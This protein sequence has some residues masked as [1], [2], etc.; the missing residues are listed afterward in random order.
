[1]KITK[2]ASD[3]EVKYEISTS[4]GMYFGTI[5]QD[6]LNELVKEAQPHVTSL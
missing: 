6:E 2:W 1:M 3:E 4:S 5:T